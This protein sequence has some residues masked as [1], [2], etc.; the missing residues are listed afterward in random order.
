MVSRNWRLKINIKGGKINKTETINYIAPN[1]DAA[2]D[3]AAKRTKEKQAYFD[4]VAPG[5]YTTS[6]SFSRVRRS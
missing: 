5:Y 6:G 4:R 2:M 3:Y 1:L